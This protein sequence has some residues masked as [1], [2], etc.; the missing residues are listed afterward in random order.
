MVVAKQNSAALMVALK[1][2][3]GEPELYKRMTERSKEIFNETFTAKAM[4]R[5]TEKLYTDLLERK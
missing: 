2:L 1:K 5:N 4:T 3:L